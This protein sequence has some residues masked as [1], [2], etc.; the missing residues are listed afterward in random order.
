MHSLQSTPD[1]SPLLLQ[2]SRHTAFD[3]WSCTPAAIPDTVCCLKSAQRLPVTHRLWSLQINN[4]Q[5]YYRLKSLFASEKLC[6]HRCVCV[7]LT[8]FSLQSPASNKTLSPFF[9]LS[10][11][12]WKTDGLDVIWKI[13][14][15]FYGLRFL[16]NAW[17]I[18]SYYAQISTLKSVKNQSHKEVFRSESKG[19]KVFKW[20][21]NN[22]TTS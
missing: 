20:H 11:R 7:S 17:Q 2:R 16:F 3:R 9:N 8:V 4:T 21:E 10:S 22:I 13:I 19:E 18:I 1:R 15:H 5:K 6:M 12:I 14:I